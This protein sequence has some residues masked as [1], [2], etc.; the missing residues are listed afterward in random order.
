MKMLKK[1]R[2]QST[3]VGV[4]LSLK[5]L[6]EFMGKNYN[7]AEVTCEEGH[8]IHVL[9]DTIEC[10]VG[11]KKTDISKIKLSFRQ[12]EDYDNDGEWTNE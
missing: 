4:E 8:P 10:T 3:I 9:E 7:N 6:F 5:E 12:N 1:T 2:K 11:G